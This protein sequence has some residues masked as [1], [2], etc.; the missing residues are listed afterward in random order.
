MNNPIQFFVIGILALG[1]LFL[2]FTV[3]KS[4][5]QPKKMDSISKLIKAGKY[6]A[7]QKTAKSIIAK[8]PKDYLAHYLLGKAYL[9]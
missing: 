5:L 4:L 1:V 3:I 6:T 7:A 9:I 2:L 8:N